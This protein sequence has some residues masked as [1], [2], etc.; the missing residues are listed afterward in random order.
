MSGRLL[1]YSGL[2][3][4]V[5]AMNRRLIHKEDYKLL[6]STGTLSEC[7]LFLKN[8]E[9]YSDYFR[10]ISEQESHRGLIESILNRTVYDS[11]ARIFHF[12]NRQQRVIL[13]LHYYRYEIT[14]LL[15]CLK[16]VIHPEASMELTAFEKVF[17]GHTALPLEAMKNAHTIDEFVNSLYG[18]EYYI[19]FLRL[20][21]AGINT[22]SEF[23]NQLNIYYYKKVWK[24]KEKL[25]HGK[26]KACYS[27]C[28]GTRIDLHNIMSVYR[29]KKYYNVNTIDI[30]NILIPISYEL[31]KQEL[32]S[33]V[34]APTLEE[35]VKILQ[36]T[37]YR[38]PQEH[39]TKEDMER[40]Y[41]DKAF[42]VYQNNSRENPMSMA[43]IHFYL[44]KKER[45][46]DLL[47]TVLECVRYGIDSDT[48]MK[49]L[50]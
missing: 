18:T 14:A 42:E 45:E 7:V 43:P 30:W 3:T 41:Y 40:S 8:N 12:A 27:D 10:E 20:T 24:L 31:K 15:E 34:Q 33:M 23:E 25:L 5:K 26:E 11:Y 44:Y 50:M 48:T 35:F 39:P 22:F 19:L 17:S 9:A 4:K 47:T 36:M 49:Y 46:V 13:H 1:S 16:H 2:I 21:G 6:S 29:C 32:T 38:L 28:I 37:K